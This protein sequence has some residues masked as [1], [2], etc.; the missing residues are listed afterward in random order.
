[1]SPEL[2]QSLRRHKGPLLSAV[3]VLTLGWAAYSGSSGFRD[4]L[5][6]REQIRELQEQNA[7][8]ETENAQKRERIERL[9]S[10]SSEQDIEIRKLNLSKPGETIFM[11]PEDEKQKAPQPRRKKR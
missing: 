4:L 6:K 7:M 2:L 8:L 10:S 5:A 11:L 1:M 3:A 9:E